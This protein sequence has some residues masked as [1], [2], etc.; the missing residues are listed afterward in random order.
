MGYELWTSRTRV[1]GYERTTNRHRHVPSRNSYA[2]ADMMWQQPASSG[3]NNQQM[4]KIEHSMW[5]YTDYGAAGR[6]SAHVQDTG[7]GIIKLSTPNFLRT[8]ENCIREG[9]ETPEVAWVPGSFHNST[10]NLS[11][12]IYLFIYLSIYIYIYPSMSTCIL[13]II[14]YTLWII[15]WCY[16]HT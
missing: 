3:Y 11:Q 4:T 7:L 1:S 2:D 15:S 5:L 14:I 13:I 8:V 16:M 9:A 10:M 12:C 6:F